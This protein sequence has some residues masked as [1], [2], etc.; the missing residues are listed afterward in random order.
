MKKK[1]R[2]SDYKVMTKEARTLKFMRESR[3]LSVRKAA[4]IIGTS[5]TQISHAENGRKDLRPDF[6]L[7][8]VTGLGYSYQDFLDLL[9]DKKEMPDHLRSECIEIIRCMSPEKLKAVRAVL[10]SF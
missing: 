2:R 3:K 8:V 5:D 4:K 7:K 6:I 10:E 9:S 1:Q